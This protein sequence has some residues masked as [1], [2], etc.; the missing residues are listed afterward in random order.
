M[1]NTFQKDTSTK[2]EEDSNEYLIDE[3]ILEN[4]DRNQYLKKL[5][6]VVHSFKQKH[7]F[8]WKRDMN[9][10][11]AKYLYPCDSN[12]FKA[13]KP[14][15]RVDLQNT[16]N[17]LIFNQG[18]LRSS[19]V[20]TVLTAFFHK[21]GPTSRQEFFPSVLFVYH[22]ALK[23]NDHPIV[24][25][26]VTFQQV[27]RAIN[28]YGVCSE[29]TWPTYS[30][31]LKT[32]PSS[33]TYNEAK[34]YTRCLYYQK[35][36]NTDLESLQSILSLGVPIVF[37]FIVFDNFCDTFL[38][39]PKMDNM[40]LPSDSSQRIGLL[41]GTIIGYTNYRNCFLIQLNWGKK[42]GMDSRFFMPYS[43]IT[44]NAY[45]DEFYTIERR[46]FNEN[47]EEKKDP[48]KYKIKKIDNDNETSIVT[49]NSLE[50]ENTLFSQG[51]NPPPSSNS[52]S[53][54]RRHRRKKRR[55]HANE[56]GGDTIK[57]PK[58]SEAPPE[59]PSPTT[60]DSFINEDTE[61]E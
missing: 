50:K 5:R 29:K 40:P 32:K 6:K 42:W 23:Q 52:N 48:T 3:E 4:E 56:K 16:F 21:H 25:C 61:E 45:C 12:S 28:K 7:K 38:W 53:N 20:C 24:D 43:Y 35:I 47:T 44:S 58:I 31:Y 13:I 51:Q 1:G 8:G 17:H 9:V 15:N 30:N 60:N 49:S 22:N 14:Y 33:Y 27:F 59:G 18:D 37:G 57:I 39:N 36:K 26:G 10:V 2:H 46:F 34:E 55:K 54:S 41:S 19:V 11:S